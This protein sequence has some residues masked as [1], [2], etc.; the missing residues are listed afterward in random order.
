[1]KMKHLSEGYELQQLLICSQMMTHVFTCVVKI[2]LCNLFDCV[3][4]LDDNQICGTSVKLEY[5]VLLNFQA[6]LF[7][8]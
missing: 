7:F 6:A 5:K 3:E 2:T 8:F 1:M 4:M